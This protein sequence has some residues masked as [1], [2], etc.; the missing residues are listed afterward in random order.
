MIFFLDEN[1]PK[2]VAKQS[3]LS[4]HKIIDIC[5]TD[6]TGLGDIAIF[7]LAQEHEPIF[8]T[9]DMDF[10]HTIPFHFPQHS[11]VIIVALNQPN[12]KRI[13]EKIAWCLEN[14]D[15]TDIANKVILL[16]DNSYTIKK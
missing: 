7:K 16:K 14:K 5:E 3:S 13:L 15:L 10:F 6:K 8:L 2:T 4:K 11:G 9:T 12:R 1:F